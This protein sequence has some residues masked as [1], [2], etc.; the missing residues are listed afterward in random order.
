MKHIVE[1]AKSLNP[2][3]RIWRMGEGPFQQELVTPDLLLIPD[4]PTAEGI[5]HGVIAPGR[6]M[7]LTDYETALAGT[8]SQWVIDETGS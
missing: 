6:E 1:G 7:P 5:K 2:D 4:H 3:L 8:Q